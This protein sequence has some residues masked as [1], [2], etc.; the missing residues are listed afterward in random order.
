MPAS[1]TLRE[2]HGVI[3]VVLPLDHVAPERLYLETRWASLVPYAAAAELLAD[4]LPIGSGVNATTVRQRVLR[5]AER[6]ENDP[7]EQW[8]SYTKG[9]DP[10]DWDDLL[11]PDGRLH[12]QQRV[13]LDQLWRALPAR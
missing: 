12:R 10:C 8:T 7:A 11:I 6:M 5:T 1:M 9:T 3:Q 13:E 4:V 2:L